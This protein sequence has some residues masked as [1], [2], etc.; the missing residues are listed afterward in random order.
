[1][2]FQILIFNGFEEMD[3]FGV[4]E[5]LRMAGLEVKL[6]CL[7]QM[8]YVVGFYG[9]RVIPDSVL[10]VKNKPDVLI[11]PGG[12]WI[13]R[14]PAGAWAEAEKVTILAALQTFSRAKCVLASVCA[15]AMLLAKAGLLTDRPATTN[16]SLLDELW[17][18]QVNVIQA[19]V[20]DDGN[21]I[22][23]GGVTSSLDLG[24]WLVQR[25]LGADKALEVS[26]KLEFEPRGCVWQ[27]SNKPIER[28]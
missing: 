16:L 23:A 19:R 11:V 26:R 7:E 18:E 22:T 28:F 6:V 13:T 14:A 12:G 25:F 3:V 9:T 27:H 1:M 20:V 15:G 21:I 8:E 10:D 5:P 2:Q 24:V 17:Q 4:F